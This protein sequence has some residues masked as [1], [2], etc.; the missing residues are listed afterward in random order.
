MPTLAL[1]LALFPS[2][3]TL[4]HVRVVPGGDKGSE[5]VAV[6]AASAR[7]LLMHSKGGPSEGGAVELFDLADPAAPRSLGVHALALEKGEG[8]TSLALPPSG[9]WFVAVAKAED[10]RARGRLLV[11]A[12]EDGRVLASFETGVGPDCVAL[13]PSGRA[14]LVANEAEEFAEV[15]DQ[16]VSEPGSL[17]L[18]RIAEDPTRSEVREIPLRE[19]A[20]APTDGRLLERKVGRTREIPLGAGPEFLEPEVVAFLPGAERALVTLQENNEVALLDLAAGAVLRRFPL[21]HTR[22]AADL[23]GADAFADTATLFAR[24][25]PDGIAVTPDGRHFVTADEGDTEPSVDKTAAG[26]PASGG[27]TLSV[28]ALESGALVGDTGPELD[29]AAARAGLYD[30]KRSKKKGCEP[31]MVLAFERAGRTLAAV[32]LERS[33]ALALVDLADP[34][35]P[36]VVALVATGK[37]PFGDE[38]EGLARYR[39]PK[40]AADYLYVANEGSNT[41]GVLRVR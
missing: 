39:D 13:D 37:D 20:L 41:L 36:R 9:A 14:A 10:P 33:G 31:E 19:P 30:K 12:L 26:Q 1:V 2:D 7:A 35:H 21:G 5:I 29:R 16:L 24:R 11:C 4:E 32:T 18:V 28:F 38:P 34:A 15:G 40:S 23:A 22:H 25:E 8:L 3:P 17:T 27:R 6:Q